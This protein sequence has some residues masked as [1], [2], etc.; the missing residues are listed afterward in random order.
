MKHHF[1]SCT[2]CP[3]SFLDFDS[4][5]WPHLHLC[6]YKIMFILY[7]LFFMEIVVLDRPTNSPLTFSGVFHKPWG[8][9][10]INHHTAVRNIKRNK[11]AFYDSKSFKNL[12]LTYK[13]RLDSYSSV[14]S[15][16]GMGESNKKQNSGFFSLSVLP[17]LLIFSRP[18]SILALVYFN[19]VSL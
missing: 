15:R 13:Q 12:I 1:L 10:C 17:T 9:K 4:Q 7:K 3:H 19:R 8:E 14:I 18:E 11:A 5:Y 2:H 16:S 6:L